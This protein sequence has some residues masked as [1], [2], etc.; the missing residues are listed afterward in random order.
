MGAFPAPINGINFGPVPQPIAINEDWTFQAKSRAGM[1]RM[2][3]QG[4]QPPWNIKAVR[5]RGVDV[6][7]SGVEVRAGEDLSG[8][9]IEITNK[10]TDLSGL[11]TNGRGD[12]VKEYWVVLFHR[13]REKW[14]PPSRYIRTSRPDQD[15]RFKLTGVPPGEYLIV[16]SD[17][18][19][20]LQA[21]DPDYLDRIQ[22]R[23]SRFT[24]GEG[25]T[26]TLDLKLTSIP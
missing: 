7:D 22:N 3:V 16:A 4:M 2:Q 11:V 15:G 19:D 24:L 26:K 25:E 17:T 12:P 23:A 13:D 18:L 6:I 9:E 8:I 14:K 10:T 21:T 1:A 5:Y 20:P